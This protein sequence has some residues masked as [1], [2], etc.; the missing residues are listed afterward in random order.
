MGEKSAYRTF[1]A[2]SFT[3][4]SFQPLRTARHLEVSSCTGLGVSC[5]PILHQQPG[6][7]QTTDVLQTI[8]PQNQ[9]VLWPLKDDSIPFLNLKPSWLIVTFQID[10]QT[11]FRSNL[12]QQV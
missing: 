10:G 8:K 5:N 4:R 1:T 2:L 7:T 3:P 9:L 6:K 12:S 11:F